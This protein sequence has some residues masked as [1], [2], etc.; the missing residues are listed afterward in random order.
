MPESADW[1]FTVELR[2]AGEELRDKGI[3]LGMQRRAIES[4]E[5][6]QLQRIADDEAEFEREKRVAIDKDIMNFEREIAEERRSFMD[7]AEGK[8]ESMQRNRDGQAS[9]FAKAEALAP[10]AQQQELKATH[11]EELQR[12]DREIAEE[13]RSAKAGLED[14][15]AGRKAVM[16][17]KQEKRQI[18]ILEKKK[19]SKAARVKVQQETVRKIKSAE[20]EW[21]NR[22]NGW[23]FKAKARIQTKKKE[24]AE[25]EKRNQ[26]KK[27][28]R[29]K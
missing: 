1:F 21:Q 26:A 3:D 17:A 10:A 29:K 28:R 27:D 4:D 24:D 25:K 18:A 11:A 23:L 16:T 9:Q 8:I 2:K 13:K 5:E 6:V 20:S 19:L 14:K 12:L 7:E 15:L 22:A